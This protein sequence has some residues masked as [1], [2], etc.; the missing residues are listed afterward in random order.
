MI[1][2][3]LFFFVKIVKLYTT[4]SLNEMKKIIPYVGFTK[5]NTEDIITIEGAGV[6]IHKM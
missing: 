1:Y 4:K 3:I 6:P 2:N 5:G